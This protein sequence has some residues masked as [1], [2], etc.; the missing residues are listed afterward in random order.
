MKLNLQNKVL[1]PSL[2]ALLILMIASSFLLAKLVV[3]QLEE[4]TLNMLNA[5]NQILAKNIRSAA[6]NYRDNIHAMAAM[7]RF[8][9]LMDHISLG[10]ASDG[11][12]KEEAFKKAQNL[13][14]SFKEIYHNFL[15]FNLTDKDGVVIASSDPANIN[16]VNISNRDYFR[17]AMS[18]QI[19][20]SS[21]LMSSSLGEKTVMVISPMKNSKG[22][23]CGSIYAILGC[24][25]LVADTIGG[26]RIGKTGY[27]YLVDSK[28]GLMLAHPDY[29]TIQTMNM[30]KLQSWMAGLSEGASGV[31]DDYYSSDGIR[32][33]VAYQKDAGSGWM[34]V[35]CLTESEL[36]EQAS[37]LRNIT[38]LLMLGSAVIVALI[39]IFVI[40][41]MTRDVQTTNVFA[42]AVASGDLEK[43]LDVTR[44]DEL[45]DLGDAL[46]KMV[47][48]LKTMI[49]SSR[50]E[51]AKA[52]E[53]AV[54]AQK[55]MNEAEISKNNAQEA[56][57][58]ILD[59]ADRL[60]QM[61]NIISSASTELA[62][63]IEQSDKSANE[64]ASRLADAASAMNEM[65]STVQEVARNASQAAS[66]SADTKLKAQA[67]AEVVGKAVDSIG[68]MRKA[69]LA[70]KDDM[71]ELSEHAKS[72]SQIMSV[73]SDIA[74]QTNL[75]ALNAA[76]EAARAGEAGRGFAVV[77]DEVRKLAEKTMASTADVGNATKAIQISTEKSMAGM[78]NAVARLEEA[79]QYARE[80][81]QALEEIVATV[82]AT[83]DQVNAIAA[84][85]EEQS[86]ASE[87]INRSVMEV[88]NLS[89]QTAQA[90]NEA[91]QAISDLSAQTQRLSDLMQEMKQ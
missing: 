59:V 56:Q 47:E 41:S 24:R 31:K 25:K 76:I 23:I 77:A 71:T 5:A 32:R 46:R 14:V 57:K 12:T 30:Y 7:T 86:A 54:R 9:P 8:R 79:T 51:S 83:T 81:G 2:S 6:A 91:S 42:Q 43:T 90:M 72:I 52:Q 11:S 66:A 65:N 39:L 15:A 4:D 48:S 20:I 34:A 74:D 44:K 45:G 60:E 33:L 16:K 40:R 69:S 88:N 27:S 58:R 36:A 67:G 18:G 29:N 17:T 49:R 84:A 82:D 89:G 78:E 80:S 62:A 19:G 87:E 22:E 38:L 35:S 85:S 10:S 1:L 26:V 21:P 37:Y 64:S 13:V 53:E 73:I 28:S 63:Q 70:L 61:I 50:E 68:E 55:A 3:N 75:L